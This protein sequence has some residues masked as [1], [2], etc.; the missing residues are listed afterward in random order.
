MAKIGF[1]FP[2]QGSQKQGMLAELATENPAVLD[3]F[4]RASEV[5]GKDLWRICQ[6]DPEGSL[7]QTEITQPVLLAAS[8]AIGRLWFDRGGP[9]PVVM[10]CLLY[11]SP[12]PRDLSTSRMPSSA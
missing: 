2:G 4:S 9:R 3:T 12:S 10:S 11:T 7:N 8:V 6:S 1:V 5:L